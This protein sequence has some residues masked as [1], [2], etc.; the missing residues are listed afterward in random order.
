MF[1]KSFKEDVNIKFVAL[2]LDD[3]NLRQFASKSSHPN[4]SQPVITSKSIPWTKKSEQDKLIEEYE[5]LEKE[6]Q[7]QEQAIANTEE[8]KKAVLSKYLEK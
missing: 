2:M 1:V 5:K 4:I 3:L 7:N 8:E 6:I